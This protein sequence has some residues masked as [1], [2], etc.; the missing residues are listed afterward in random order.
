MKKFFSISLIIF[1]FLLLINNVV[2]ASGIDMNL[3]SSNANEDSTVYGSSQTSPTNTNARTVSSS[4]NASST[5]ALSSSN[6]DIS[7]IVNIILVVV[8]I[9]LILLGI[10]ILIRMR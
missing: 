7:V 9:V 3:S 6:L 2:F 8:G 4:T 1:T 5:A 10:A